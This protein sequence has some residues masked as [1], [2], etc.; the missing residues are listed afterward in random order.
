VTLT[1][2][3]D[4][5]TR[6][7]SNRTRAVI[8]GLSTFVLSLAAFAVAVAHLVVFTPG[9]GLG[10]IFLLSGPILYLRRFTD[11]ARRL[12]ARWTGVSAPAEYLPRPVDPVRRP[13]G[14]YRHDRTLYRHAWAARFTQRLEWVLGDTG[15][16]RDLRWLLLAPVTSGLLGALPGALI[17]AGL[18]TPWLVG[19]APRWL[20]VPAGMVVALVGLWIAPLAVTAAGAATR[21][22]LTKGGVRRRAVADRYRGWV[23]E[24]GWALVQLAAVFLLTLLDIPLL[25]I[26][27]VAVVLAGGLGMVFLLPPAFERT[28]WLASLRRRLAREWS[29]VDIP[30]P[31]LPLPPMPVPETED[32]LYR[33]GGRLYASRGTARFVQRLR[34]STRDPASWRELLWFAVD[35]L[36]GGLIALPAALFVGGIW[37]LAV[38]SLWLRFANPDDHGW[39]ITTLGSPAIGVPVGLALAW[40][41]SLAAPRAVRLHGGWTR[42]LLAPTRRSELAQRVRNLTE[43]R[44]DAT[45]AQAAELRRIERDLHDGA[46]ARIIAV[47]LALDAIEQL[48]DT[49]PVEAKRIIART[50]E[51]A[52]TAL[53][54]LRDL[55]RGIHPPVL[56]ER[57]LADAVRAVALDTMVPVVVTADLP[58]QL[59]APVESAAYFAVV[60]AL[61]NVARHAGAGRACVSL[62]YDGER[63]HID[64]VDDGRGSVDLTRGTGLTGMRRR[65]GMFDGTLVIDSPSGGPTRLT[66]EIPCALSSPRTST[67]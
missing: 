65:L 41:G 35:P 42:V 3:A 18:I 1:A 39:Y 46:Q 30:A 33:V 43:S 48:V 9:F 40:L 54:E 6:P 58:A 8:R 22:L 4:T 27:G 17:A 63:L 52:T 23:K 21:G 34:L 59:P 60:E 61:A 67:S 47:G 32:G 37:G 28:R 14:T 16:Y 12:T 24:R 19:W 10:M 13:D 20:L 45:D 38:P 51:S 15:T 50:K 29:H 49:D 2:A 25:L 7:E 56:A 44:A 36:V 31:Y 53:R 26:T 55:V 64:V 11:L 62:S 57:G 66:M 5:T